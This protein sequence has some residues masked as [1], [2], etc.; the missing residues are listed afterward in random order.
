MDGLLK[1]KWQ[2]A[3]RG[4]TRG[5]I[6]AIAIFSCAWLG[7]KAQHF[8]ITQE[9]DSLWVISLY[10][11]CNNLTDTWQLNYPVY[12]F[13][14][15]DINGDGSTDAVVGVYKASRFFK[16]PSRR[17]FIFKNFY[18]DIRPLWLGSRLGGELIDFTVVGN[19]IRAIE[20]AKDLF[21]VSDYVWRGF[22]MGF[23][24]KIASCNTI[25]ECYNFL[26]LIKQ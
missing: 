26:S 24:K 12:R 22:G 19:K 4:F 7:G 6:L 3:C 10:D 14:T 1:I 8:D 13:A 18:G 9:S 16:T 20:A 25:D 17:V 23:E 2:C 11:N 15:A 5:T 21:V